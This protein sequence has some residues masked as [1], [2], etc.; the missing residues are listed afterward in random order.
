MPDADGLVAGYA[1]RGRGTASYVGVL[2]EDPRSRKKPAWSCPHDHLVATSAVLCADAEL[3]RRVQAGRAVFWLLHCVPCER[4]WPDGAG[5]PCP[6]CGVPLER[7]KLAVLERG[8]AVD[9]GKST[10]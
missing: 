1:Y 7:L 5:P 10:R 3:D 9:A 8:P 2:R 6:L 4:W